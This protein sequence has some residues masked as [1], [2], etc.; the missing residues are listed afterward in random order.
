LVEHHGGRSGKGTSLAH[1]RKETE[2]E[3]ER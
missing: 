3:V 2:E 1:G